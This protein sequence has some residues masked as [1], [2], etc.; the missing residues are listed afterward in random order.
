MPAS[1]PRLLHRGLLRPARS[2]PSSSLTRLLLAPKST[3]LTPSFS[4]LAC[5]RVSVHSK[6]LTISVTPLLSTLTKNRGDSCPFCET[7]VFRSRPRQVGQVPL[8]N[9]HFL[10]SIFKFPLPMPLRSFTSSTS[11]TSL[12][13]ATDESLHLLSS[14]QLPHT[15]R[16]HRGY[17]PSTSCRPSLVRPN[18]TYPSHFHCIPHSLPYNTR[19]PPTPTNISQAL[20]QRFNVPNVPTVRSIRSGSLLRQSRCLV[21]GLCELL[22]LP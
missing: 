8:P 19:V 22:P 6:R 16:H 1:L 7:P 17:T 13:S 21:T 11:L 10:F 15:F 14:P 9:F 2:L 5:H 3:P 20:L 18:R 4:T 12:S